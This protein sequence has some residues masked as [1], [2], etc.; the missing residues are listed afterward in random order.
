MLP[1]HQNPT[2]GR[3]GKGGPF[4]ATAPYNFV[5]LPDKVV[6][7][8]ENEI[9]N[10]DVYA[11]GTFSGM[12]DC[13]L[14]TRTP[15]YV[16]AMQ[17][18][19]LFD[20]IGET[21]FYML[22][23]AQQER[24]AQF[25]TLY[26][27]D[28]PVIPGSSLRGMLRALI[29]IVGYAKMQDVTNEPLIFR[30][31]GDTTSLGELYRDAVMQTDAAPPND[32]R[33]FF[34]PRIQA[35]FLERIGNEW[36]IRPAVTHQKQ[37]TFG[38][39]HC[40]IEDA[41]K[42][43][44]PYV[45]WT[46]TERAENGSK[47]IES[48]A[49]LVTDSHAT[50]MPLGQ[51]ENCRNAFRLWVKLGNYDYQDVQEGHIQ[52]KYAPVQA[53]RAV[54]T[55]D[56]QPA[57][58]AFSGPMNKKKHEAVVL[59]RDSAATTIPLA[60]E[61]VNAYRE[62]V[63]P[64]QE[65]LLGEHGALNLNQPVF[66]LMGEKG[67]RFFGHTMMLRLPYERA[68]LDFVPR[69]LRRE[70]T[71]DLVEALFG[72]VARSSTDKRQ[73]RAGRVFFSDA[74][75]ETPGAGV[76]LTEASFPPKI[77]VA[78]KATTFQH[79]L[80][81]QQPDDQV[82][83]CDRD[84]RERWKALL[85]HYGSRT[86]TRTVIRGSKFYWH[87]GK[88]KRTDIEETDTDKLINAP[89]QFTRMRP[90]QENV[91]FHF[92][93]HFENLTEVELGALSWIL[94][95]PKD[96]H[97]KIGMGKPFGMGVVELREVDLK[98]RNRRA[99]Y[100]KLFTEAG[101]KWDMGAPEPVDEQSC[102]RAFE[103]FVLERM[104]AD[105][106]GDAKRLSDIERIQM[107][108]AL[109]KWP[110]PPTAQTRAMM[111]ERP[112]GDGAETVNEFKARPVLPDALAI[113]KTRQI[114]LP[115]LNA[116]RATRRVAHAPQALPKLANAAGPAPAVGEIG[117]G[118]FKEFA[119]KNPNFGF[120]SPDWGGKD[121]FVHRNEFKNNAIPQ[122]GERVRFRLGQGEKGPRA[123]QVIIIGNI[124]TLQAAT[125]ESEPFG[126]S[127]GTALSEDDPPLTLPAPRRREYQMGQTFTGK[128]REIEDDG[129]MLVELPGLDYKQAW[130]MIEPQSVKGGQFRVGYDIRCRI[131]DITPMEG[132][133]IYTCERAIRA[134][135]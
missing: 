19:E 24:V 126:E 117:E 23:P 100:E 51:Y 83:G 29:E 53:A 98:T 112:T 76:W 60:P 61:L 89:K 75:C 26:D 30:A 71:I 20:A 128:I 95:L 78:P 34:T 119:R 74:V 131:I 129:V 57:V 116:P 9:P 70:D 66:Y 90:V 93:I 35:G 39:I 3:R 127:S 44:F 6:T 56:Y 59:D 17:S 45:S 80:T 104:N 69:E 122:P 49:E 33:K 101:T 12:F 8:A 37:V 47:V 10:H 114:P 4:W 46:L 14:V 87:R 55:T 113:S 5:P 25:F 97:P 77:L 120:I 81:Q 11:K 108:L 31:V 86:P 79:Y 13:K 32:R 68:A 94:R 7:L 110:G 1:K 82:I 65:K 133:T 132:N 118:T 36:Q 125:H 16:R 67:V 88:L 123:T 2:R 134:S 109:L 102:R 40:K 92:T 41:E 135:S 62:Q 73:A 22:T 124:P 111:I 43:K 103:K 105:E 107:L 106:R 52:L 130:G 99:R 28:C 72:F 50:P 42:Q 84:G 91:S 121:V 15:M 85:D 18:K 64:E 96:Y 48:S 21:P 115:T 58:V 27:A 63:S 38:R 54:E